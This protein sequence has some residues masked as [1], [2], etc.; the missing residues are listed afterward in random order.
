MIYIRT[1]GASLRAARARLAHAKGNSSDA[2][3]RYMSCVEQER[4][5]EAEVRTLE[6]G[7]DELCKSRQFFDFDVSEGFS[8]WAFFTPTERHSTFF[9]FYSNLVSGYS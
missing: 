2:M 4:T 8:P 9:L 6:E 7:L 1:P 5:A 3:A